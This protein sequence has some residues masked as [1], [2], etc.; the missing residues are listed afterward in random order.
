ME[1]TM[2]VLMYAAN[3]G[4]FTEDEI[5]ILDCSPE[6]Y[7]DMVIALVPRNLMLKYFKE[8]FVVYDGENFDFDE[9][10]SEESTCDDFI[11]LAEFV[12]GETGKPIELDPDDE[13]WL[14]EIIKERMYEEEE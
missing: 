13:K 7:S 5:D 14:R 10:F 1:S 4:K 3:T 9:W 8:T 2:R 11:E 12:E 6:L